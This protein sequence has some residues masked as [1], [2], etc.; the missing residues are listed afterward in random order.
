M[1]YCCSVGLSERKVFTNKKFIA[2]KD[3][4]FSASGRNIMN[5][6]MIKFTSVKYFLLWHIYEV[7]HCLDA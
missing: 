5:R 2:L 1:N 3:L 7:V 6:T 4:L